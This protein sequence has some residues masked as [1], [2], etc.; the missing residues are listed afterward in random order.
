MIFFYLVFF[1]N[2]TYTH[3]TFL[4]DVNN[5]YG[6]HLPPINASNHIASNHKLEN[7]EDVFYHQRSRSSINFNNNYETISNN[8]NDGKTFKKYDYSEPYN[9]INNITTE[10][11]RIE[12]NTTVKK[13]VTFKDEVIG[14]EREENG[15]K[16][17]YIPYQSRSSEYKS[18][19]FEESNKN[20]S[21]H[22]MVYEMNNP[23]TEV[24]ERIINNN[25]ELSKTKEK[26]EIIS[27][28]NNSV[29]I[30]TEK[31]SNLNNKLYS[32][33]AYVSDVSDS[34]K[35]KLKKA[36][37]LNN[38][39]NQSY[40][41]DQSLNK[42]ENNNNNPVIRY[43]PQNNSQKTDEINQKVEKVSYTQQINGNYTFPEYKLISSEVKIIPITT[44][45]SNS[46]VKT[47]NGYE[48]D[49]SSGHLTKSPNL[50]RDAEKSENTY[51]FPQQELLQKIQRIQ[52]IDQISNK[53]KETPKMIAQKVENDKEE[54]IEIK[55]DCLIP[56]KIN[57]N[58]F[59]KRNIDENN[60]LND[61][62]KTSVNNLEYQ[63]TLLLDQ[64]NYI[65]KPYDKSI[66]LMANES[67]NLS[68]STF[69][70]TFKFN[71][72]GYNS[73]F[74]NSKTEDSN[75]KRGG[76][77]ISNVSSNSEENNFIISKPIPNKLNPFKAIADFPINQL[78]E[79]N[80]EEEEINKE[81]FVNFNYPLKI[82]EKDKNEIQDNS[83]NSNKIEGIVF[84]SHYGCLQD[85]SHYKFSFSLN[86]SN[87]FN[88]F[89]KKN[90]EIKNNNK[91]EKINENP[92]YETLRESNVH[93]Y[94][95]F[96]TNFGTS[97]VDEF[98]FPFSSKIELK[99]S[100]ISSNTDLYQMPNEF[101]LNQNK[102]ED[103]SKLEEKDDFFSIKKKE[104]IK[105]PNI[106]PP[107]FISAHGLEENNKNILDYTCTSFDFEP[108][109][110]LI[111]A[112]LGNFKYF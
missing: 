79:I 99:N 67:K 47:I 14:Q 108:K 3:K 55:D 23:K 21:H 102:N 74:F 29:S 17:N 93:Y 7:K 49:Y 103:N 20:S 66:D 80:K 41:L 111:E 44:S 30:K 5:E 60:V 97:K 11:K 28:L 46:G 4:A 92:I 72:N 26:K 40:R 38:E 2:K 6:R 76:D 78:K 1:H 32:S 107:L 95:S 58:T 36:A 37:Y 85:E 24:Y 77:H 22:N 70:E 10:K 109:L 19:N 51:S 43:I 59:V 63:K 104:E 69:D 91:Q 8:S 15:I 101:P 54:T 84:K 110:K 100:N 35:E 45:L 75:L 88:D 106:L 89:Q 16:I 53:I 33:Y 31:D 56:A 112:I 18:S 12:K 25:L 48:Q 82:D 50:K 34:S 27:T 86:D 52:T 42:D 57:L 71:Q 65:D 39:P 87:S 64:I 105:S 9:L 98:N 68:A 90:N 62:N 13:L 83:R 94:N 61:L 73:F 96:E 81:S